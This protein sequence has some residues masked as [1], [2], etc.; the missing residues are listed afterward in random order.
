MNEIQKEFSENLRL[1]LHQVKEILDFTTQEL[2]NQIGVTR[3]S[4]SNLENLNTNTNTN[5]N[6]LHVIAI[7]SVIDRRLKDSDDIH[8]V[9]ELIEVDKFFDTSCYDNEIS[10]VDTWF[11]MQGLTPKTQNNNGAT[12]KELIMKNIGIIDTSQLI[13]D[14]TSLSVII[15][16]EDIVYIPSAV[17]KELDKVLNN[18]IF[19]SVLV[20]KI[21]TAKRMIKQ[22]KGKIRI[23]YS[24]KGFGD[25]TIL[26]LVIQEIAD[27]TVSSVSVYTFDK[28]LADECLHCNLS[29]SIK[30]NAEVKVFGY[31]NGEFI[32]NNGN[33]G[34]VDYPKII[35]DLHTILWRGGQSV[36]SE[37]FNDECIVE[38]QAPIPTISGN[39]QVIKF[40]AHYVQAGDI[41]RFYKY[42]KLHKGETITVNILTFNN[43]ADIYAGLVAYS[44]SDNTELKSEYVSLAGSYWKTITL[45]IDSDKYDY[46]NLDII[47]NKNS[48]YDGFW[49]GADGFIDDFKITK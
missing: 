13:N 41:Y 21:I 32:E 8:K 40:W 5:I 20:N 18:K 30:H 4:F 46:I 9:R 24:K 47:A 10:L 45:H 6:S 39:N 22:Y 31:T 3:Q 33:C 48:V 7:L 1:K 26:Q 2:A 14:P 49:D 17:L 27:H 35:T 38:E 43:N 16:K 34:N 25:S 11:E 12:G 36:S 19:D 37:F 29:K 44:E 23:W 28:D 42:I 15:E